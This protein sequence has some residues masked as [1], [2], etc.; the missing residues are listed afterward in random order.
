MI[1]DRMRK[2][3]L[4]SFG[5]KKDAFVYPKPNLKLGPNY[6]TPPGDLQK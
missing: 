6:S 1:N 3:C 2:R 5:S 4:M